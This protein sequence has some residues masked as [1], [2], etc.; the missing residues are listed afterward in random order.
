[1]NSKQVPLALF[2]SIFVLAVLS[3]LSGVATAMQSQ[4][5]SVLTTLNYIFA[6]V[7]AVALVLFVVDAVQR[8]FEESE[9]R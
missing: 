5:H 8:T 2:G 6:S 3:V 9:H 1:M 4:V 7:V